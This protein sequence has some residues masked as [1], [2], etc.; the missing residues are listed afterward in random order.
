VGPEFFHADRQPDTDGRTDGR[1]D[2]TKPTGSVRNF[3]KAPKKG[4]KG[5]LREAVHHAD[6]AQDE[7][8]RYS[9]LIMAVVF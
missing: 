6:L 1:T 5:I 7:T 8:Q 9:F 2:T 3:A 4:V